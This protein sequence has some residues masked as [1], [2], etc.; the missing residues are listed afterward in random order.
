MN[1]SVFWTKFNILGTN[2]SIRVIYY[3]I[4]KVQTSKKE[5]SNF[6]SVTLMWVDILGHMGRETRG[7]MMGRCLR[8]EPLA[9]AEPLEYPLLMESRPERSG[10]RLLSLPGPVA[11]RVRW[12][13]G[14]FRV[15][16]EDIR[17]EA[18]GRRRRTVWGEGTDFVGYEKEKEREREHF[19]IVVRCKREI[20]SFQNCS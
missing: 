4:P 7:L 10:L 11:P 9:A 12:P 8:E 14:V 20:I 2:S 3:T 5:T 16:P 18:D 6:N 19:L 17:R 15:E 1:Q 13:V